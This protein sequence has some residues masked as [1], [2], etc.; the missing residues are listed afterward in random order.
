MVPSLSVH[1]CEFFW[2]ISI[3]F[4][5]NQRN[6]F[7]WDFWISISKFLLFWTWDLQWKLKK[8]FDKKFIQIFLH[9]FENLIVGSFNFGWYH[10]HSEF[11]RFFWRRSINAHEPTPYHTYNGFLK[12]NRK[13]LFKHCFAPLGLTKNSAKFPIKWVWHINKNMLLMMALTKIRNS[14]YNL[15]KSIFLWMKIARTWGRHPSNQ[16]NEF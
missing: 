10:C 14:D 4:F 1:F 7:L 5:E 13:C 15:V 2:S 6:I 12:L 16:K 11:L 3:N 8:S 9:F